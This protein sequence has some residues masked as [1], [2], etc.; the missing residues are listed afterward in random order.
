MKQRTS[1]PVAVHRENGRSERITSL[2]DVKLLFCLIDFRIRG[3]VDDE[4]WAHFLEQLLDLYRIGDI[5]I[6]AGQC[7]R[8]ESA[9]TQAI[10]QRSR[11][12]SPAAGDDDAIVNAHRFAYCCS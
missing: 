9:K 6:A 4:G 11:Q 5:K 12:H 3:A 7:L 1:G 10:G 2:R 8:L